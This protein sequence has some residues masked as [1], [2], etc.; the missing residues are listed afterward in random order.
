MTLHQG[1]FR[2]LEGKHK[3]K[4]EILFSSISQVYLPLLNMFANLESDDS[5]QNRLNNKPYSLCA[6]F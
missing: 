4:N 5:F 6:S 2:H 3:A 1:Y